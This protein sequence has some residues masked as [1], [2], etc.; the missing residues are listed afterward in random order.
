MAFV[1]STEWLLEFMLEFMAELRSDEAV[2]GRSELS[3]FDESVSPADSLPLTGNRCTVVSGG[4]GFAVT[5]NQRANESNATPTLERALGIPVTSRG[6][7]TLS[8]LVARL[9]N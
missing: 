2:F 4:P 3:L 1:R 6:L 5:E 9:S 8:R 7:P